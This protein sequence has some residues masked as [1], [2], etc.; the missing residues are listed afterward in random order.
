MTAEEARKN[1]ENGV[2]F[3]VTEN[4]TLDG[5]IGNLYYYGF[6][7]DEAALRE[8][9]AKTKDI[10]PGK[11][12]AIAIPTSDPD[13]EGI[14]T[15]DINAYYGLKKG[16]TAWEIA[17]ILLNQPTYLQGRTYNYLFMP[18]IPKREQPTERGGE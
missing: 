10:T 6:V 7:K 3:Y 5:I 12:G 9:L 14:N 11:E 4:T 18:G 1:A 13:K 17:D 8:A 15:I 16:M 2:S